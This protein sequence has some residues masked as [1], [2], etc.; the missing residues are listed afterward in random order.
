MPDPLQL[1]RRA[2]CAEKSQAGGQTQLPC[3]EVSRD[4]RVE[5]EKSHRVG[6]VIDRKPFVLQTTKILVSQ[7]K[8]SQVNWIRCFTLVVGRSAG[9]GESGK[10]GCA[11]SGE[12]VVGLTCLA[13]LQLSSPANFPRVDKNTG[14]GIDRL[15][16]KCR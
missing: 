5:P 8:S 12:P 11:D 1:I 4:L 13:G 10:G 15:C 9:S 6:Y 16:R 7:D 14:R 2:V 3:T